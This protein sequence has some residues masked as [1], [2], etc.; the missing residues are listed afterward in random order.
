[1]VKKYK[2]I[3]LAGGLGS[4]LYPITLGVSKQLIPVYDKPMVYYPISVLLLSGIREILL[5]SSG[6]SIE[7]YKKLLGD[8]SHFGVELTYAVQSEPG[9]LGQAF[10]IGEDFIGDD[11]V[12]LVLGD[13]VFYGQHFSD[14][15]KAAINR[16]SG[17]TIFGYRVPDPERFGVVEFDEMGVVLSLEEK[18][19]KPKSSYAV[20]GLYYYDNKVVEIAKA[21]KVSPRGEMEITDIN[22]AY[23]QLG[24]LNIEV[25]GRGFAWL[26]TGTYDSLLDAGKFVQTIEARQGLKVACL[27]EI[28]F[29]NGWISETTLLQQ[30]DKLKNT[31]YGK[32]LKKVANGYK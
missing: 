1:M 24:K 31:S 27:E 5:I 8:G 19:S 11:N 30:A 9:G 7:G 6:E 23:Q 25:L 3:V 28:A 20:T 21:L 2:G 4:R 29:H 16:D 26:D 10:T 13:N 15:L 14:K 17:A 22:K 12:A 32:Y 18:P